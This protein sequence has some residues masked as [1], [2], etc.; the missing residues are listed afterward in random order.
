MQTDTHVYSLNGHSNGRE[1]EENG[2]NEPTLNV[3][4]WPLRAFNTRQEHEHPPY[5]RKRDTKDNRLPYSYAFSHPAVD[6]TPLAQTALPRALALVAER[7]PGR[8]AILEHFYTDKL[9]TAYRRLC[10]VRVEEEDK[11]ERYN[12]WAE[13]RQRE[14]DAAQEEQ[15]RLR[16]AASRE[17]RERLAGLERELA[18]AHQTAADLTAQ[19]GGAYD[20]ETP[21]TDAVLRLEI[22]P[23][24][25]FAAA[26]KLPY[27]PAD[28]KALLPAGLSWALTGVIGMMT[29]LSI[30]LM[31]HLLEA[32]AMAQKPGMALLCVLFGVASAIFGKYAVALSFRHTAERYYLDRPATAWGPFATIG[33]TVGLLLI[34]LDSIVE[35]SGL[36]A[37]RGLE[38]AVASL[39]GSQAADNNDGLV[40]LMAAVLITFGYVVTSGWEGYVKGRFAAVYNR[41]LAR[42]EEDFRVQDAALR[43]APEVQAALRAIAAVWEWKRECGESSGRVAVLEEPF[44][45]KAAWLESLRPTWQD[46]LPDLAKRRI[47][48]ASDDFRGC[49]ALFDRML[50]NALTQSE[51]LHG[52]WERVVRAILG[53]NAPPRG[54]REHR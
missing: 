10:A 43:D 4:T 29:G 21:S 44:I 39:S 26:E 48:D 24:E 7:M 52:W 18:A 42:Q 17:K 25:V 36:L 49:Q 38:N 30:G 23:L 37:I 27:N 8:A 12:T 6:D 16:D 47:E 31:A 54:D 3:A 34:G 32:D 5:P 19:T 40:Y 50:D 41:L 9:L 46:D 51:P 14:I 22:K 11:R 28:E 15:A 13:Q 53:Y 2:V 45:R 35:R 33:T 1:V 20:P